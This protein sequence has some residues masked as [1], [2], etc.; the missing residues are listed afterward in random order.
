MM[1]GLEPPD[2]GS[3]LLGGQAPESRQA[4]G[5]IGLAFQSPTLMPWRTVKQNI[6]L[7]LEILHN[8]GFGAVD[9]VLQ[10]TEL[11]SVALKLP[12]EL[13]GGQAQRVSLARALVTEPKFLLLDEP[14]TGLDFV[15]RRRL[16]EDLSK[17]LRELDTTTILVTHDP[18]EAVLLS[19]HIVVLSHPP[20]TV[21]MEKAVALTRPRP[22][23]RGSLDV[24]SF[25]E[26]V[27]SALDRR[28]DRADQAAR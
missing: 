9:R 26:L 7:P 6:Q 21:L 25:C 11:D 19:D 18:R 5:E 15:L 23:T 27:E 13:S 8:D 1:A 28:I 12:S 2:S 3:V 20:T 24:D 14:F 10:L 4:I 16:S 17:W 22:L